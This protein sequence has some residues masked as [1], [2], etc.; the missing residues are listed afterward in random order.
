MLR[1]NKKSTERKN[2]HAFSYETT[3]QQKTNTVEV[4]IYR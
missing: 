2:N 3:L 4:S 1:N